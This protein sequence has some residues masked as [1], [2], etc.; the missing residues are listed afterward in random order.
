MERHFAILQAV[1][2]TSNDYSVVANSIDS[3]WRKQVMGNLVH[4]GS[5]SDEDE[6]NKDYP[7]DA[8]LCTPPKDSSAITKIFKLIANDKLRLF[9]VQGDRIFAPYDGGID[10]ILGTF[11]AATLLKSRFPDWLSKEPFGL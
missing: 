2:D 8:F 3:R 6:D 5:F 10:I 9:F 11:L 4:L 1:I 7:V